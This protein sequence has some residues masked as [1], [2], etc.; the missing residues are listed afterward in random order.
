MEYI[1]NEFAYLI[2]PR[3][4]RLIES[5]RTIAMAS[6]FNAE[7]DEFC[8]KICGILNGIRIKTHFFKGVLST[9]ASSAVVDE[10]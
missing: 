2:A 5:R 7:I 8:L 3:V 9:N 6:I 4:S 1:L 10:S